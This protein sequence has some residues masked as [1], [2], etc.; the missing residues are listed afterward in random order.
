MLLLVP[1]AVAS[2]KAWPEKGDTV[3]ISASFKKLSA[4]SPV[5]GTQMQYDM[6]PCAKLEIVKAN[7]KKLKWVAKDPIGGKEKLQGAWLP[8][9]HKAKA[10]CEAQM[11]SAGEPNVVRSGATFRIDTKE[12]EQD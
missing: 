6:P 5:A 2:E 9:M 3:Y 10:D 12:P 1:I 11:S 7:A 8:R 4:P